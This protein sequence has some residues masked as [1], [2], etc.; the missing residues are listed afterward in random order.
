MHNAKCIMHNYKI[1]ARRDSETICRRQIIS[2][3]RSKY[4]TSVTDGY[5]TFSAGKYITT[6]IYRSAINYCLQFCHNYWNPVSEMLSLKKR[7]NFM[8][9]LKSS[10]KSWIIAISIVLGF[11][12]LYYI[13]FPHIIGYGFFW[14]LANDDYT[15]TDYYDDGTI[16]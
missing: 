7:G 11:I 13:I 5:I 9:K 3:L 12:L 14:L 10:H 15:G 8:K 6:V 4:I 1:K 16:F 2:H